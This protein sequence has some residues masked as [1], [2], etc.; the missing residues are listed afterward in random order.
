MPGYRWTRP[1][2]I[3]QRTTMMEMAAESG[4]SGS[5]KLNN[6][7]GISM[8][9]KQEIEASKDE[10]AS[11][12]ELKGQAVTG[13]VNERLLAELEQAAGKEKSGPSAFAKKFGLDAFR[14]SKTDAERRAA[15]EEARNL[16][17]V[18]PLVTAAGAAFALGVAYGL[19]ILT[20]FLGVWFAA[21]PVAS[22][23]FFVT[24]TTAV[25][26]NVVVGIV[27]LASGFFGVTGLGILLLTFR[28]A[29]GVATGELDPTP[30]RNNQDGSNP[31]LKQKEDEFQ[32]GSAWDLM[33][34]KKHSRRK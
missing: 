6:F 2:N 13:T 5:N 31:L 24:R 15:I 10:Q 32:L 27:S 30:I 26:R 20:T 4:S 7:D 23:I 25:F 9:A 1:G 34:N 11:E 16:N 29:Y 21:H 12:V 19:W 33:M 18:N 8:N 14:S 3:Q 22:E 28:V 17:G